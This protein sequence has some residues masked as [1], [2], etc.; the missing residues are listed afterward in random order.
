MATNIGGVGCDMLKGDLPALKTR[1]EVWQVPG[2]DGYGAIDLG[3]GDARGEV[4]AIK[5]DTPA[6]VYAWVAAIEALQGTVVNMIMDWGI[7]YTQV[8]IERVS[9]P[10]VTAAIGYG[11]ARGEIAIQG[12][13]T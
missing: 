1:L 13:I 8:L 2:L 3:L 12:V 5:H 7:T 9:A 6:A 10:Q 11:G 4:R